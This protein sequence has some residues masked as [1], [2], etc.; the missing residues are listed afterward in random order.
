MLDVAQQ[1]HRGIGLRLLLE[2]HEAAVTGKPRLTAPRNG[3][4][5][6]DAP[7][8]ECQP[9]GMGISLSVEFVAVAD[10]LRVEGSTKAVRDQVIS[11]HSGL[12]SSNT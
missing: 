9:R 2:R 12:R 7:G 11:P 10:R 3:F 6:K 4:G 1:N 5:R 8:S